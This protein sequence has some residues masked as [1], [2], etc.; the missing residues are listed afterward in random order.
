VDVTVNVTRK[1]AQIL[2]AGKDVRTP[3]ARR[4]CI[5]SLIHDAKYISPLVRLTQSLEDLIVLRVEKS[6]DFYVAVSAKYERSCYGMSLQELVHTLQ[7]VASTQLPVQKFSI[8]DEDEVPVTP[9]AESGA[10][11]GE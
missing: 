9:T 10:V 11:T 1:A 2:N 8:F 6:V 4:R 7:P 3:Y 5:T